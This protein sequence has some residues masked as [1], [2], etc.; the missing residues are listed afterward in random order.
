MD[1]YK[2]ISA[3]TGIVTGKTFAVPKNARQHIEKRAITQNEVATGWALFEF[4]QKQTAE[5]FTSLIDDDNAEQKAIFQTYLLMLSDPDFILQIKRLY[6]KDLVCIESVVDEKMQ[7]VA[8]SLMM[9]GDEYLMQRAEDIHDV[10]GRVLDRLMGRQSFS[11]AA[12]PEG[13]ILLAYSLAPSDASVLSKR[14]VKALVMEEGGQS[15]HLSILARTYGIPLVFGIE[16]IHERIPND[17]DIIVDGIDAQIFVNPDAKTIK[18][19]TKKIQVEFQNQK[20]LD[21]FIDKPA[22]TKDGVPIQ[23]FANIGSVEEARLALLG[24]AAGIGLFRTEFLFM[25]NANASPLLTTEDAQFAVYREVL[26]LMQDK[27]VVIRTF[28]AGGDKELDIFRM[29]LTDEKNPL[30]GWRAIR[31]CLDRLDVFKT[32]LRALLRASVYGNLKIMIPLITNVEQLTK[33]QELIIQA[34]D[35]L[36][37]EGVPFKDDTHVGS[38]IETPAAAVIADLLAEHSDFFSIGSNDLTQYTLCV[39]REN[40]V[41]GHLFNELHPA[42]LRLIKMT[43][44]AAKVAAIPVS[45]CGEMAGRTDCLLE[46]V[47]LGVDKFSM[48]ATKIS[49]SKKILSRFTLAEIQDKKWKI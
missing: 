47:C 15:S 27:P 6:E 31:M 34:K 1:V 37:K 46:L 4:A 24:G 39:D 2:G 17:T 13:A 8:N 38:M 9:S 30:L 44:E 33:T 14:S 10:F 26:E 3:S 20:V 40:A 7:E 48:V 45:V 19:Y 36:T 32:Q 25:A 43:I 42:V 23:L 35:E 49:E 28:D 12:I 16:H 29:S 5:Y 11:F 18:L 22:Q 41:V 21:T